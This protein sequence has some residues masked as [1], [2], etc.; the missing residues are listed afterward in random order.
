[1]ELPAN[2]SYAFWSMLESQGELRG[3]ANLFI[4]EPDFEAALQKPEHHAFNLREMWPRSSKVA[5][6]LGI[7]YLVAVMEAYMTDVVFELLD[8]RIRGIN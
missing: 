4:I 1:M 2:P 7:V 8:K 6:R 5:A 3:Y